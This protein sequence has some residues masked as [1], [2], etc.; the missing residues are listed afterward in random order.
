ME[1]AEEE[2]E[3]EQRVAK[4]Q[5]T[6]EEK[7]LPGEIDDTP[8]RPR[9]PI[10]G[11]PVT[12]DS[13]LATSPK[14]SKFANTEEPPSFEGAA[15]STS[16]APSFEHDLTRRM[17]SQSSRQDY[18]SSSSYLHSKPRVKLGPRPSID[19]T[20]R[21]RS[22]AGDT[23]RPVASM[24]AGLKFSLKG[25]K[26]SKTHDDSSSVIS[27][28]PDS[29]SITFLAPALAIPGESALR[30][31]TSD[32]RLPTSS[33]ISVKS[34]PAISKPVKPAMSQ[35]KIRLMK[36]LQL[37]EK[38]KLKDNAVV[39]T[40][41]TPDVTTLTAIPSLEITPSPILKANEEE[42]TT[43]AAATAT[44]TTSEAPEAQAT[45]P[46]P[47]TADSGSES[48]ADQLS[49]SKA[50]SAVD[51]A[52][53]APTDHTSEHTQTD[54]RP[55][56]MIG[57][58]SE[59]G[60]STKASSISESTDETLQPPNDKLE[61][62]DEEEE[63]E[64]VEIQSAAEEEKLPE[65]VETQPQPT[66]EAVSTSGAEAG[67]GQ[68]IEGPDASQAPLTQDDQPSDEKSAEADEQSTKSPTKD[69][70]SESSF[71]P[72]SKFASVVP[73]GQAA[74]DPLES[75]GQ[76]PLNVTSGPGRIDEAGPAGVEPPERTEDD[77]AA[78]PSKWNLPISKYSTHDSSKSLAPSPIPAIV[79]SSAEPSHGQ[80]N[81]AGA[82]AD[83]MND[84][85]TAGEKKRSARPEPIQTD[86]NLPEKPEKEAPQENGNVTDEPQTATNDNVNTLPLASPVA[87]AP[88]QPSE[89]PTPRVLRTVSSPLNS[90]KSTA[91][92]A[93]PAGTPTRSIS[94]GS[95]FQQR[96]NQQS[97]AHLAP[98]RVPGKLGGGLAS[99]IKAFEQLSTKS[100]PASGIVPTPGARPSSAFF[101]VRQNSVRDGARSPSVLERTNSIYR[102]RTPTPSESLDGS[103]PEAMVKPSRERSGSVASRLSVFEGGNAPRGR[104]ETVQVTARIVRE[105]G[106]NYPRAPESNVD[107]SEYPSL[108]LKQSPLIVDHRRG[109]ETP[110]PAPAADAPPVPTPLVHAGEPRKSLQERRLSKDLKAHSNEDNRDSLHRPGQRTSLTMARDFIRD[111]MVGKDSSGQARPPS[112]HQ[113]GSLLSRLSI[114]TRQKSISQD[115]ALLSP[116]SATEMSESG[117]ETKSKEGNRASRLMRRLSSTFSP[118]RKHSVTALTSPTLPEEHMEVE[119]TPAPRSMTA[120]ATAGIS[121]MV[122][123]MGEVNVQF[124]ENLLWK[125]RIVSLDSNGFLHLTP[126]Q[127][128]VSVREKQLK[129][130]HMSEFKQPYAPEIEFQELPNSV[131]LDFKSGSGLQVAFQDR[132][133][134]L[135]GLQGKPAYL[136]RTQL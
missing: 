28:E 110:E 128:A 94:S 80:D 127:G 30:P 95:A 106:Q 55:H 34:L 93:P 79:T 82:A 132:A 42:P 96:P 75:R 16:P 27:E 13:N 109:A 68:S 25:G 129:R 71:I 67:E 117:D 113:S 24:P 12:L 57:A 66:E 63:P 99:R 33:G 70:S 19:P 15:R 92:D 56:S 58:S 121:A 101:S 60:D 8:A 64:V 45:M 77:P 134:Q 10:T 123:H 20:H 102:G 116:T 124:P 78:S 136:S 21:P 130:F 41:V 65:V 76:D 126:T 48:A 38:K 32:G 18:Y 49:L 122:S 9:S 22:S 91:G 17:S 107:P 36:A 87:A 3:G 114:N 135:S 69:A 5:S 53:T 125:R 85:S 118:G 119:K 62:E 120:P 81:T 6:I 1:I 43:T 4:R 47:S 108:D 133:G 97:V 31:R 111:S 26:K 100:P 74:M 73:T 90:P 104:P 84:E 105:P 11:P 29:S 61:Q 52:S 131:C 50:D 72:T 40:T 39:E 88:P 98:G 44:T 86:P 35:E 115:S 54:S 89:P 83:N 59:V 23:V 51:V 14:E 103:S 2:E 7:D 112:V 37:R 46:P